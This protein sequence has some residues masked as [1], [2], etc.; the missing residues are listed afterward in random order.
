MMLNGKN[1]IITGSRRGIGRAAAE[2]F[3]E[4]GANIWA[5][6]RKQDDDFE[7]DMAALAEK[8]GVWIKP[9][10]FDMTD[11]AEMK[12][13]V[14]QIKKSGVPIDVLVNNAGVL[15]DALLPMVSFEKARKLFDTN[16]WGQL[17]LTSYISRLMMRQKGGSIVFTASYIGLDGNRGQ[18]IYG[19]SKGAIIT[20]V[21][22]LANELAEYGVRVNA[23]APGVVDTDMISTIPED[24]YTK[25]MEKCPYHR[26]AQPREVANVMAFLASDLSSYVNGQIIRVDGGM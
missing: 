20:A 8:N 18:T 13:A 15:Y 3:A 2:V 5:C 9:V 10:Y 22:S 19:A 12:S 21:K 25:L 11:E 6:A 23:V 16:V 4:S 7:A 17:I 1:V 24:E 14:V 26:P